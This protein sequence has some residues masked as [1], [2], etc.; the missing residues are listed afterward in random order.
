MMK[1]SVSLASVREDVNN[2][3]IRGRTGDGGDLGLDGGGDLAA[4]AVAR[5]D[6]EGDA[7]HDV[8]LDLKSLVAAELRDED[9]EPLFCANHGR[10]GL[11][12]T[13][14]PPAPREGGRRRQPELLRTSGEPSTT[15]TQRSYRTHPS[16][17]S[18]R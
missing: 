18:D 13:E 8:L 2:R 7:G 1:R 17:S 11:L 5:R 9:G 16:H 10:A 3:P 12:W 4:T 6:G 14:L 15:G